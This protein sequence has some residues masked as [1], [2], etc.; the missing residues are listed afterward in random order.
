M[1]PFETRVREAA[2]KEAREE[3]HPASDKDRAWFCVGFESGAH[4]GF[5]AAVEM[6]R[7]KACMGWEL[8]SGMRSGDSERFAEWLEAK[9]AK[10]GE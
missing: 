10:E 5:Q 6:L 1:T 2:E 3:V 7:N 9:I 8:D 4:F